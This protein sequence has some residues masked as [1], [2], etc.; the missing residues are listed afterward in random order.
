[1]SALQADALA[2]GRVQWPHRRKKGERMLSEAQRWIANGGGLTDEQLER[3][4]A[5]VR[6]IQARYGKR[7]A[8][9]AHVAE[10]RKLLE[11]KRR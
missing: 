5:R 9:P 7:P 3:L 8:V 4:Y 10:F 11:G 1:M 2:S 6:A